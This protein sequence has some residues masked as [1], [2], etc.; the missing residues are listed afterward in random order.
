MPLRCLDPTGRNIHSFDLTDDEWRTLTI[1]NKRARH[2]AMPCCVAQVTL[3]RSS[4]GTPFFAHKA[5]GECATAPESKEHLHLKWLAVDAARTYGW[6]AET[7][8]GGVTPSGEQWI[9]DVL[10]TKGR[11]KVAFE[12][13]WSGQTNEETLR[14]QERYREAG[15]R[16]LWLLR[17][18]GFPITH[19]LPAAC[20]G[21]SLEDGFAALIPSST[22][23][24]ARDRSDSA[25]W[26]QSLPIEAFLDAAFGGHFKFGVPLN[27][28]ATVFIRGAEM[29]CWHQS[30]QAKT[31]VVTRIEVAFGPN[32]CSF[33]LSVLERYRD[34]A[35]DILARIPRNRDIGKIKL[36][37]S[38]TEGRSY[39]SNGC[40]R[41]DRLMGE[42][43]VTPV[44]AFDEVLHSYD[45][46]ISPQWRKAIEAQ[47]SRE[48]WSV[49]PATGS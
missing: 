45:I 28:D 48:I 32:R 1:E 4:L 43:F 29:E 42:F 30:C 41:C 23:M 37:D 35:T 10:A 26:H 38:K 21:G 9:A 27:V 18:P 2:L 7:E 13:Q 33:S 36:R 19:D 46:R 34:P 3:K 11:H 24:T 20:I 31:R 47:W 14:R 12:I 40:V 44:C 5:R 16:G 6:S 8:V 15:I 25:A 17:Q 49:Y 39:L 22:Y